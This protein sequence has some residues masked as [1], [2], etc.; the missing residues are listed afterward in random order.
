MKKGKSAFY[1]K[2][3]FWLIVIIVVVII[4]LLPIIPVNCFN[5]S[6]GHGVFGKSYTNL[7]TYLRGNYYC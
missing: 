7:I 2:W 5:I 6:N 3:W 1:K 4:L